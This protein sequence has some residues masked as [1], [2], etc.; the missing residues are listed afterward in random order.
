MR[1]CRPSGSLI[2]PNSALTASLISLFSSSFVSFSTARIRAVRI[3]VRR[4]DSALPATV[5]SEASA[6]ALNEVMGVEM[7]VG[8]STGKTVE[9]RT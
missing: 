8:I 6:R 3:I 9:A 1:V 2:D 4:F 7:S 5:T